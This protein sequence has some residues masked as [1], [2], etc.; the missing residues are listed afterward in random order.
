MTEKRHIIFGNIFKPYKVRFNFSKKRNRG[1]SFE[2]DL[3]RNE[4]FAVPF[5]ESGKVFY[6]TYN[7]TEKSPYTFY[8]KVIGAENGIY[9]KGVKSVDT[10]TKFPYN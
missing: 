2:K 5:S 1:F 7:R 4:I 8:R 3:E 6:F 9:S 10:R